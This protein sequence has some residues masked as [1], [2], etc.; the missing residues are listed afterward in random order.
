MGFS[1]V[2]SF[3]PL[4]LKEL[5]VLRL[6][7]TASSRQTFAFSRDGALPLS[8]FNYRVNAYTKTPVNAVWCTAFMALLLGLLAFAGAAAIGAVFSLAVV[9]QYVAYSIP[10]SARFLGGQPFKPGQFNLGKFV[11]ALF[12]Y[13]NSI[14]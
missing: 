5:I 14:I 11:R 9:G 1:M 8:G 13:Y 3:Y 2:S 10:I 7:L 6:Q 4:P 12:L